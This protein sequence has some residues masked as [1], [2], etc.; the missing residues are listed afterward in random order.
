MASVGRRDRVASEAE[1]KTLTPMACCVSRPRI[2]FGSS[3]PVGPAAD[4]APG[5]FGV[6]A[7]SSVIRPHPF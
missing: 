5:D 7:A 3:D 2:V 4:P 6:V 1:E